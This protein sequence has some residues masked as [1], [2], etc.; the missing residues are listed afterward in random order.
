MCC[1]ANNAAHGSFDF[2]GSLLG[3]EIYSRMPDIRPVTPDFAV[4]PQ[5]SPQDFAELAAAGFKRVIGNRPDAEVPADLSSAAL[6]SAAEAAG[7]DYVHVPIVGM[8]TAAAVET[9]FNAVQTANGPVLAY[10]RSGTRSITAWAMGQVL[11]GGA[12]PEELIAL[13]RDAGYDL[14]GVLG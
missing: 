3:P 1:F 13:G 8:P 2:G 10:C 4:A 14:S 11:H 6:A 5:I 9:I 7:L 12:A